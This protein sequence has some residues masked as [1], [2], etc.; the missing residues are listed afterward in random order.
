MCSFRL[1]SGMRRRWEMARS[2]SAVAGKTSTRAKRNLDIPLLLKL[3]EQM[4]LL[5]RF[6]S[7]A[8][9]ACRKG[10]TPGFLHLYIGEEATAVGVCVHLRPTDWI[11]STHRGHG[12][13]LAKGMDPKILMAELFG[14]RHGCCGG[15]GGTMHLYDRSIG[16]FGTDGIVAAGISHA[17]GVGMSARAN[18][19]DDIGVAFFGDGASNHAG[20]HESINFAGIQS[21]PVVFVCENNLYATAT[22]LRTATLNPEIATRAAAYGIP[23]VAVDGNDVLAIYDA[24]G[25]AVHRARR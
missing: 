13:S 19:R 3:Y 12:H 16:L 11:T 5:R 18:G 20:F 25:Q 17:V 1:V 14:K 9:I 4:Q 15:R 21:A 8:Q 6:E 2:S 7:V 23:G 10:E 24:M 22:P